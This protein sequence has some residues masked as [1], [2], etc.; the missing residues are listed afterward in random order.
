VRNSKGRNL[1]PSVI[2]AA[3]VPPKVSASVAT[4][5]KHVVMSYWKLLH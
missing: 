1:L 3:M 4:L 2:S 5:V